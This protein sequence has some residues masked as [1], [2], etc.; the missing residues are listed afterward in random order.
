MRLCRSLLLLFR[1]PTVV[2]VEGLEVG[3]D[4]GAPGQVLSLV[5]RRKTDYF[6]WERAGVLVD[7]PPV[8]EG[9]KRI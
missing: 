3:L 1:V 6:L 7:K 4:R 9:T 2:V 5:V 8:Q